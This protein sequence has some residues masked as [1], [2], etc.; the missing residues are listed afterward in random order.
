M[1]APAESE[2]DDFARYPAKTIPL[3]SESFLSTYPL[4][5]LGIA[6]QVGELVKTWF[7][8]T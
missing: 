4:R 3:P 7:S 5:A 1:D 8:T 6:G 2:G